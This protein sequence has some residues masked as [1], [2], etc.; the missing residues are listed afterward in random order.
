MPL[1]VPVDPDE[2]SKLLDRVAKLEND[3]ASRLIAAA[4]LY[5][6]ALSL[7]LENVDIAY[8]L[9]IS[10]VETVSNA[11][12]RSYRP[13]VNEIM[14]GRENLVEHL[15]KRLSEQ[16][17]EEIMKMIG[18]Q[19]PWSTKKFVKFIEKYLTEN[20]WEQPDPLYPGLEFKHLIP[21]REFLAEATKKIYDSRSDFSHHGQPYPAHV[22]I[23]TS[24]TISLDTMRALHA[25]IE[26]DRALPPITW[27]ERVAQSSLLNFV[28]TR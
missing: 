6:K 7:L 20:A 23:G 26:S 27:F 28:M 25:V 11:V 16:E 24:T 14:Q 4:R 2:L 17:V 12:H 1:P 19:I 22:S 21:K 5:Q 8:Q 15:R 13:P 3:L 9:L 18:D 10:A